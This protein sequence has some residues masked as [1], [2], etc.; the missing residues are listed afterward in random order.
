[1]RVTIRVTVRVRLRLSLLPV[2]GGCGVG[3]GAT[4]P[5]RAG[6]PPKLQQTLAGNS[7]RGLAAGAGNTHFGK[8][9]GLHAKQ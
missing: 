1:M 8:V 3:G 6:L 4:E 7:G 9:H 5:W 2:G